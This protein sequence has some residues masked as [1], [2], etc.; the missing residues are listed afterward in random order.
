M[1]KY[2]PKGF[3]ELEETIRKMT[4]DAADKMGLTDCSGDKD[5]YV[6]VTCARCIFIAGVE[7]AYHAALEAKEKEA[8]SN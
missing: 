4:F 5:D 3:P 8:P 2:E 1:S 6:G 7:A